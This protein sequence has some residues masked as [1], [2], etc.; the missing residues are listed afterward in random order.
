MSLNLRIPAGK[1]KGVKY[2]V[3]MSRHG[4]RILGLQFC[5]KCP[6]TLTHNL[7]MPQSLGEGPGKERG[8]VRKE[9]LGCPMV[10]FGD[11]C[12]LEA[13]TTMKGKPGL[14]RKFIT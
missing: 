8:R 2:T 3:I 13:Q 14:S 6:E 5:D 10:C 12:R 7:V 11:Q 1:L 4:S 9:R